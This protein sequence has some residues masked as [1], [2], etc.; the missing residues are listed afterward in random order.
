MRQLLRLKG[1]RKLIAGKKLPVGLDAVYKA[2]MEEVWSKDKVFKRRVPSL[3]VL[4]AARGALS[5]KMLKE[6]GRRGDD[7]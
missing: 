6:C 2:Q 5:M 4:C 3:A 1:L 7:G